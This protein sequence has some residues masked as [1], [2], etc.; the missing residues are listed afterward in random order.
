[1]RAAVVAMIAIASG[2]CACGG[3]GESSSSGPSHGATAA[4]GAAHA[5]LEA[6]QVARVGEVMLPASLVG[7]AAAR[8]SLA[9]AGALEALIG[10][11]LLAQGAKV[12]HLESRLDIAGA[13]VAARAQQTVTAMHQRKV[14]VGPPTDAEVAEL[15]ALHWREV[16]L[17]EQVHVIH[18]VALRPEHPDPASVAKAKAV[19]AALEQAVTGATSKE[20]FE[21]RAKAVPHEGVD[22]RV[23]ELPNFVEDGRIATGDGAMDDS[24]SRGAFAVHAGATSPVIESSFGW[25]VVRMIERLPAVHASLEERRRAFTAET[26]AVRGRKG[27]DDLLADLHARAHVE[28]SPAVDT[29]LT[30]ALTGAKQP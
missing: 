17:P 3:R 9:P 15:T 4:A 7:A 27:M 29:I 16:D 26:A 23:E 21:A 22:V 2:C 5:T 24:F 28:I 20:D 14:D 11:A 25:H 19:A 13:L 12:Q 18:A 1:M 30:E 8:R 6:G 10:D